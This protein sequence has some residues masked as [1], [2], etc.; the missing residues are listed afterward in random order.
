MSAREE[1][2][3]WAEG[4]DS[5]CPDR[6]YQDFYLVFH[7]YLIAY[8]RML[9]ENFLPAVLFCEDIETYHPRSQEMLLDLLKDFLLSCLADQD[10][11]APRSTLIDPRSG[12][13][14]KPKS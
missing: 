13:A 2:Q 5:V 1:E 6:L 4:T 10:S 12:K 8:F 3:P 9:E 11:S 7:L 14:F